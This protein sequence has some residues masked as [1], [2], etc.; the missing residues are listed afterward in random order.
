MTQDLIQST[1]RDGLGIFQ[2]DI[3]TVSTDTQRSFVC[4]I[5]FHAHQICVISCVVLLFVKFD[6]AIV[7]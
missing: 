7:L 3:G 4:Q 6:K 1:S 2:H 5:R